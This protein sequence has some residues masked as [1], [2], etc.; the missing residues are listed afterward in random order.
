MNKHM[1]VMR[2]RTFCRESGSPGGSPRKVELGIGKGA[3]VDKVK[4]RQMLWTEGTVSARHALSG[5]TTGLSVTVTDSVAPGDSRGAP[6]TARGMRLR[7][8]SCGRGVDGGSPVRGSRKSAGHGCV[9]GC[10][11]DKSGG[12]GDGVRH[13]TLVN[14]KENRQGLVLAGEES[15]RGRPG[16]PSGSRCCLPVAGTQPG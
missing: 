9:W 14:E 16:R 12:R 1:N 7:K 2:T 5:E 15:V 3:G 8:E 13:Q 4:D 6:G 11:Q 10:R